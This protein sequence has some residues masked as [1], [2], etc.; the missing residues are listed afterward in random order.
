MATSTI[1]NSK[2]GYSIGELTT[3]NDTVSIADY[4]DAALIVLTFRRYAIA[5]TLALPVQAILQGAFTSGLMLQ[6]PQGS[7]SSVSVYSF[8]INITAG[9]LITLTVNNV[10]YTM[11]VDALAI[12]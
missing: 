1:R 7:Q 4:L 6:M 12:Y 2:F 9:G 8:R 10:P 11:Y 5:V 3:V